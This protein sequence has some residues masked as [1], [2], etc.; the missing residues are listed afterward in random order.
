M[1]MTL[2]YPLK[3]KKL[4]V[5]IKTRNELLEEVNLWCIKIDYSLIP[6]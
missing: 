4:D 1:Q 6:Q 3:I 2:T 5:L